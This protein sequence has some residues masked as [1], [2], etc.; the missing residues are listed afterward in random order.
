MSTVFFLRPSHHSV[1]FKLSE[2]SAEYKL[3]TNDASS[4]TMQT[5]NNTIVE[6][7]HSVIQNT[8]RNRIEESTT[9]SVF[10][11]PI[12]QLPRPYDP[13]AYREPISAYWFI[14]ALRRRRLTVRIK[15]SWLRAL[16]KILHMWIMLKRPDLESAIS[17]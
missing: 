17:P 1:L 13:L 14:S 8:D 2:L 3:P 9:I 4:Q 6:N 12:S 7:Q 5:A 11:I 16:F 15:L 10:E